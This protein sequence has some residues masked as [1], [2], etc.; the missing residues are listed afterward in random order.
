MK[1]MLEIPTVQVCDARSCAYNVEQSCHARAITIG[2]GIHAA[3]DTF[4]SSERHARDTSH[5]AG[6]GACKVTG[7]R[8]NSDLECSAETIRVSNHADCATFAPR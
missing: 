5:T 6:V 3:C 2:E 8:Y 1:F 4:F 7:C